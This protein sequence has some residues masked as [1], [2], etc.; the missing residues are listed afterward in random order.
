M[1]DVGFTHTAASG[2]ASGGANE[3]MY[4]TPAIDAAAAEVEC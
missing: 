3:G 2:G 1:Y 4:A